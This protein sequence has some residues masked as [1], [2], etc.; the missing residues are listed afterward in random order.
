MDVQKILTDA[1]AKVGPSG[2]EME[3][4]EYFAEQFRPFVD[5]VTVD[6]MFNVIAHK[7]GTGPK[8]ALFAHMDEIGLMVVAI[9][10]GTEA[11]A[12]AMWAAWIRVFCLPAGCGCTARKNFSAPL[13]PCRRI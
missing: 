1:A 3:V 10:E 11:S 5:E 12:W 9:E 6:S 2:Q 8:V 4:A 7:K 13:V